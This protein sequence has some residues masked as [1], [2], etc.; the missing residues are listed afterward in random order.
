MSAYKKKEITEPFNTF[1]EREFIKRLLGNDIYWLLRD[2]NAALAGGCLTSLFTNQPIN[3][4]D[5]FFSTEDD[6]N[7]FCSFLNSQKT[8][9]FS[10]MEKVCETDNAITYNGTV[11]DEIILKRITATYGVGFDLDINETGV[12]L[13]AIRPSLIKYDSDLLNTFD[14]SVCRA[15]YDFKSEVFKFDSQF[16]VDLARKDLHF[17]PE[18]RLPIGSLFRMQKYILKGYTIEPAEVLKIALCIS[19]TEI[20]TNKDLIDIIEVVPSTTLRSHIENTIINPTVGETQIDTVY[21]KEDICNTIDDYVLYGQYLPEK[22]KQR[23][24]DAEHLESILSQPPAGDVICD[25][26]FPFPSPP[27]YPSNDDDDVLF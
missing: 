19:E 14:F 24:K 12:T 22:Y 9:I 17:N 25:A 26:K 23:I 7:K 18:C 10:K 15:L 3:D 4:F 20:K 6:F 13:Q 11:K 2:C 16:M 1:K 5:L 21:N 27:P 8:V